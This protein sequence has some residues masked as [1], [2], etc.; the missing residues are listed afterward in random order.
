[1]SIEANRERVRVFLYEHDNPQSWDEI[2]RGTGLTLEEITKAIAQTAFETEAGAIVP[3]PVSFSFED[4][5][6]PMSLTQY[7]R[8][9]GPR[10]RDM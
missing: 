8:D 6:G 10:R 7:G 9:L 2:V 3:E 5:C 4:Y 1:M